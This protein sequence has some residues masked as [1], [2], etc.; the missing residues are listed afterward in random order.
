M[1]CPLILFSLIAGFHYHKTHHSII[2]TFQY[3]N[4][5]TLSLDP[6]ALE[7][8]LSTGCGEALNCIPPLYQLKN[9][10]CLAWSQPL[11]PRQAHPDSAP[12]ISPGRR[13]GLNAQW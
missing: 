10:I 9:P 8:R 4:R 7:G 5:T 6:E 13:S 2:P 1:I 12:W 11:M 3:S